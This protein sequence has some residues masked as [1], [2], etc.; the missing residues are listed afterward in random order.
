MTLRKNIEA[1]CDM[2]P[3][4]KNEELMRRFAFAAK[5]DLDKAESG[6][7][8]GRRVLIDEP[9]APVPPEKTDRVLVIPD[10]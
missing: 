9:G 3:S 2:F 5:T 7:R 6:I 4:T 10:E 8:L 1:I